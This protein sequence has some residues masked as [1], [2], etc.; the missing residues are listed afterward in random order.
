MIQANELRI[1]NKFSGAGIRVQTVK[2]ILD[3]GA[4]GSVQARHESKVEASAGYEHLILVQENG[5]QYKPVD[6]QPIPLSPEVLEACGFHN[7]TEGLGEDY[8]KL[9]LNMC[10]NAWSDKFTYYLPY[11]NL[12]TYTGNIRVTSLHQLQNL[13]FALTGTELNYTPKN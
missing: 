8:W 4:T 3:Y 11:N 1:G 9:D 13:Y 2:E 12:S 7:K 5:N 6:M 10:G